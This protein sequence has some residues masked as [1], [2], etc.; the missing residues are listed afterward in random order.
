MSPEM[1]IPKE[2]ELPVD[3]PAPVVEEFRIEKGNPEGF[4]SGPKAKKKRPKPAR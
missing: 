1:D 2:P 3:T 4:P